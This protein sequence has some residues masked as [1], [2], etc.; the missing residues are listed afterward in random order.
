MR[1][2]LLKIAGALSLG[3][4]FTTASFGQVLVVEHFDYAPGTILKDLEAYTAHSGEGTSSL[5]VIDANLT[6][7]GYPTMGNAVGMIKTGED[8]NRSFD[9]QTTGVVYASFMANFS[10]AGTVAAGDYFMH[11]MTAGTTTFRGRVFVKKHETNP[12]LAFGITR[13]ANGAA[14]T[15]TDFV[16]DLNTTHLIVLKYEF[17]EGDA[18]DICSLIINPTAGAAEPSA[19]VVIGTETQSDFSA[20]FPLDAIALRQGHSTNGSI[21]T[22]DG[23]QVV[24]SWNSLFYSSEAEMLTFDFMNAD[25]VDV[26]FSPVMENMATITVEVAF[27]TDV[28][29]LTPTMTISAGAT[30]SPVG[31]VPTNFTNPV[32][33]TVTA[34]DGAH[35]TMY[36][37]VV[38]VGEAP[39]INTFPYVQN[40]E[41]AAD[42][43]SW[44]VVNVDGIGTTWGLSTTQ[45]HTTGG[46]TSAVHT[47]APSSAGD[48]EGW[49]I[50]PAVH[51]PTV[52]EYEM[53]F[54]SYNAFPTWYGK[55]SV[56][57]STGSANP[58][59]N[60]Y[61]EVWT[62]SSVTASWVA[63]T[64]D[65]AAYAGQTIY[66]AFIYEGNDAHNWFLDDVTIAQK[67]TSYV[68]T[69]NVLAGTTP[70]EGA[71]VAIAS[72]NLTTNAAGV[73]TIN[74]VDGT[75]PYVVT[76]AGMTE[77]TGNVVV[78]GADVTVPVTM[79]EDIETPY[80]LFVM[81]DGSDALFT[82]N[83]DLSETDDMESYDNFIIENIGDYT[84]VDVDGSTTYGVTNTTFTNS[85]YTGSFIVFNPAATTPALADGA[86]AAYSGTKYLAC[87]A[88]TSGPA[89][90]NNDWLIT[91]QVLG[92]D[93]L[94]F[95]FMAK[96]VTSQYG[97]ERFK[98]AVSTTGTAPADFTVISAGTYVTAPIA[99][100]EYSYDLSAYAGQEIYVAI[101]CV[102][103]DAFAFFV[104][105]ITFSLNKKASKDFL[106][107]TVYLDGTQV[108]EGLTET[109]YFFEELAVGTHT[110]GVKSV[111]TSG[112]SEIVTIDFE[113]SEPLYT[114]TFNVT[115]NGS[116]VNGASIAIDG[117]TLTTNAAGVAT[118]ELVDGTYA[119]TIT[120]EGFDEYTSEVIV[121]GADVVEN[122]NLTVGI[123]DA[124]AS[125]LNVYPNP[126]SDVIF[127]ERTS[128][129]NVVV[130]IY[131]N[132]G[133]VINTFEMNEARKEVS[134]SELNSGVYFIRMVG[135]T[136]NNVI[137]FI[138]K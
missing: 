13:G 79:N 127:I 7:P 126:A 99:W 74:L 51:V 53:E 94:N 54:W 50:T 62:V 39:G 113:I 117:E 119:Y 118:I 112:A 101:N 104:D 76:F 91:P 68:V 138:K 12:K 26:T 92:M 87:F 25:V 75:Y 70:L 40:F 41:V 135:E 36:D 133:V 37:V 32:T 115:S 106:G 124:V 16:Y 22:V 43:A 103:S 123:N 105:D 129:D 18:N 3:L 63:A 95:S 134:V 97:L 21:Q 60:Q 111:Y 67:P 6:Y 45:N 90:P 125:M 77:A 35:Y 57:I 81:V 55:N 49:L 72:Q 82:W 10:D 46:T 122:A 24:T 109:A 2:K 121:D 64:V 89:T 128:S 44:M 33:Y 31:G 9:A 83:N 30:M 84:L 88:A 47:Y 114:V 85:G 66:I 136:T 110:A 17:V 38:V 71:N 65:L 23:I 69:F 1:Q 48:Q 59:D 131:N 80:G 100:T 14:A 93:G 107:Y 11:F 96:S 28:T 120:K 116:P 61:T 20:E 73:A 29:T 86:W 27:G 102:S 56:K 15:W 52:G 137:R 34:E 78:E 130:E 42:L 108:A 8:I 19:T 5:T 132:K 58:A 98:V 4:L